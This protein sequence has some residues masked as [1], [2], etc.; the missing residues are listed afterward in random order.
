MTLNWRLICLNSARYEADETCIT[1]DAVN[2]AFEAAKNTMKLPNTKSHTLTDSDI[3]HL[4]NVII[5]TTRIIS[6]Q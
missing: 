3:D 2:R 5:E 4:A 1:Y 6:I